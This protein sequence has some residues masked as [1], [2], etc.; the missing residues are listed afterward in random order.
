MK[1]FTPIFFAL[2]LTACPVPLPTFNVKVTAPTNGKIVGGNIDCGSNCTATLSQ[3]SQLTLTAEPNS[4]FAF[5]EWSGDCAGKANPC[6]L[7]INTDNSVGAMFQPLVGNF[8]AELELPSVVLPENSQSIVVVKIN[9]TGGFNIPTQNFEVTATGR[10]VGSSDV[11]IRISQDTAQSSLE[12][13]VLRV[14]TPAFNLTSPRYTT[15]KIRLRVAQLEQILEPVVVLVP[16]S[17]G[18]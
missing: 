1:L 2:L 7:T 6:N 4:G 15:I 9:R 13:L 17:S 14:Q 12:R 18:C 5:L 11:L 8:S 16:C 3:G 10:Y